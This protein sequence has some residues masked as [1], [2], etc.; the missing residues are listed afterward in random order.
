MIFHSHMRTDSFTYTVN[1]LILLTA[2][3][4][5]TLSN[6]FI[7]ISSLKYYIGGNDAQGVFIT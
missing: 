6:G 3:Q 5:L 1:S 4:T 2:T 7:Q